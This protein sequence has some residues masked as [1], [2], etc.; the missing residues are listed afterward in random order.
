VMSVP[1]A[2]LRSLACVRRAPRTAVVI[3][4]TAPGRCPLLVLMPGPAARLVVFPPRMAMLMIVRHGNAH[5]FV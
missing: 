5:Q 3:A 4:R 1:L 2:T